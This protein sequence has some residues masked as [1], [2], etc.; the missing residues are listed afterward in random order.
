MADDKKD[1]F[2]T[3]IYITDLL[4]RVTVLEKLLVS[5]GLTTR[6][7]LT[8]EAGILTEQITQKILDSIKQTK[9]STDDSSK[10]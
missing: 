5:L 10:N 6:E 9:V 7:N 2:E 3:E 8:K 1:G 4:V